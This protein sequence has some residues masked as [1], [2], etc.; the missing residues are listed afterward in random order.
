MGVGGTW[1]RR[2]Q[3][4]VVVRVR[5]PSTMRTERGPEEVVWAVIAAV[6]RGR[7]WIRPMT[8]RLRR[9]PGGGGGRFGKARLMK[10]LPIRAGSVGRGCLEGCGVGCCADN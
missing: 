9:V 5:A 8:L 3:T 10:A 1:W 2:N 7:N 6:G 4:K